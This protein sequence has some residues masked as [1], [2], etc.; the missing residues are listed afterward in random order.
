MIALLAS[1]GLSARAAKLV[2]YV[3]LPLLL[4]AGFA[5]WL[6]L[7]D[8]SVVKQHDAA[9]QAEIATKARPADE[10]A[11]ANRATTT[12][13]IMK[14]QEEITNALAP[15]PDAGLTDR[16]RARACS[17]WLRQHPGAAKPAGC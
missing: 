13:I 12:A 3:G 7:H 1:L 2:A 15:L 10:K 16:Q 4:I 17:I 9:Q 8:R 6:A 11:A 14:D 5:L